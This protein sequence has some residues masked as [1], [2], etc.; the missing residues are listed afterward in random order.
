[1][2]EL[3]LGGDDISVRQ[4]GYLVRRIVLEIGQG[5]GGDIGYV[6]WRRTNLRVH[7]PVYHQYRPTSASYRLTRPDDRLLDLD[8]QY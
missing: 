1:M 4:G 2:L 8:V 7:P 3:R 6:L 5:Q